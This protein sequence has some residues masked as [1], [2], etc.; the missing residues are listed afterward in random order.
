L[1]RPWPASR[2]T[3]R[4]GCWSWRAPSRAPSMALRFAS[5]E[6]RRTMFRAIR[7]PPLG[8]FRFFTGRYS[9]RR[10]YTPPRARQRYPFLVKF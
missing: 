9:A 8:V 6:G 2:P 3:A 7:H 10:F 5:G 1:I 4:P